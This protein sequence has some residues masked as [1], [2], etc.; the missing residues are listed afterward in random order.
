MTWAMG[1]QVGVCIK[2]WMKLCTYVTIGTTIRLPI[3]TSIWGVSHWHFKKYINQLNFAQAVRILNI[4]SSIYLVSMVTSTLE[5]IKWIS[6]S[7]DFCVMPTLQ[8]L[9]TAKSWPSE[10]G[11][12]LQFSSLFTNVLL[13]LSCST[14]FYWRW[15]LLVAL[16]RFFR[17][18]LPFCTT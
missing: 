7:K 12:I 17:G 5:K 4:Y 6:R 1:G 16:I 14:I 15:E 10:A 8:L 9:S 2:T 3:D 13:H 11:S 18:A